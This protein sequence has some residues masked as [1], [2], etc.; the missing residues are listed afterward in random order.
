DSDGSPD[1]WEVIERNGTKHTL[2]R[3]RGANNRWSVVEN[4]A[5]GASNAF[6][7]TYCWMVDSTTDLHGNRI[8]YEYT[9]GTGV[10]YPSR[11]SYGHLGGVFHEVLFQ[12]EDRPDAFDDYRPTFAARLDRRLKRIEVRSQGQLVRAYNF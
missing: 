4:P 7:R 3:F 10:L 12:F 9:P 11:I 2:G 8:E 5:K 1:A 6:D